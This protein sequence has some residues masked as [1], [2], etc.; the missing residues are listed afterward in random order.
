MNEEGAG[1]RTPQ[2][3]RDSQGSAAGSV[4][5]SRSPASS[6]HSPTPQP[7]PA[8][9]PL[10]AGS[11]D[12]DVFLQWTARDRWFLAVLSLVLLVLLGIQFARLS[13]WGL[14]PLEVVRPDERKYEFQLDV[15][16]AGWVE[17]MQLEG[18]GEATAR[19]IVADRESNGPF[20]SVEDVARVKGIGPAT[21]EKIRPWLT[22][23]LEPPPG[24]P[25]N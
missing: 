25:A 3:P 14:K 21:L 23:A 18:I 9:D 8:T 15:N 22:C 7:R 12:N 10:D 2:T 4:P 24:A 16:T 19:K 20:R 1:E 5:V 17:W 6:Q 11:V 13:G